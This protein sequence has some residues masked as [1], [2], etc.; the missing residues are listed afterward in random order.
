MGI[1][2]DVHRSMRFCLMTCKGRSQN[3]RKSQSKFIFGAFNISEVDSKLKAFCL[4]TQDLNTIS[5]N[6]GL[7]PSFRTKYDAELVIEIYKR[8]GSFVDESETEGNP[9]NVSIKRIF[10]MS[11]DSAIYKRNPLSD[12]KQYI[13]VYEGKYFHQFDH[14]F[15]S[16]EEEVYKKYPNFRVSPKY[17]CPIDELR[18]R[19]SKVGWKKR[20]LLAYRDITNSSNERSCIGCILPYAATSDTIRLLFPLG[21][22]VELY[23]CLSGI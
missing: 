7:C 17:W 12:T 4:S 2:V 19:L 3:N 8:I 5:P 20:Y 6:T 1:F 22:T 11:Y 10:S 13:S 18:D 21:Q 23:S 16:Y 9:W 15:S 14:R